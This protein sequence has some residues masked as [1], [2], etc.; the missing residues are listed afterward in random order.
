MGESDN[1]DLRP[2]WNAILDIYKV[3]ADI[4]ERHGIRHQAAFGTALGAVRH[5][6]FIPWDDDF[7]IMMPRD[8]YDRFL[9]VAKTDLPGFLQIYTAGQPSTYW[10]H[11]AA[12]REKRED[13]VHDVSIGTNLAITEGIYIDIFPIDGMPASKLSFFI[14]RIW[15]TML[16]SGAYSFVMDAPSFPSGLWVRKHIGGLIARLFYPGC[17]SQEDFFWKVETFGKKIP[18]GASKFAGFSYSAIKGEMRQPRHLF[19]ES[20]L[21]KF[22][23]VLIPVPKDYERY[24]QLTFGDWHKLPPESKR[25]PGHQTLKASCSSCVGQSSVS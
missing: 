17:K 25:K 6:G 24:L 14:W 12:V 20:V 9:A 19:D 4:C 8:D 1:Y 16:L 13:V 21:M 11:W 7:D 22:E 23:D 15:R 10:G 5:G 2:L 18:Y 3:V